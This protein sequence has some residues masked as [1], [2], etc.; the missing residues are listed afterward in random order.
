MKLEAAGLRFDAP[1]IIART[2]KQ[3]RKRQRTVIPKVELMTMK[4]MG[5]ALKREAAAASV[6]KQ[7]LTRVGSS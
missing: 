4:E 1:A 5:V 2:S 3:L 6:G 7:G